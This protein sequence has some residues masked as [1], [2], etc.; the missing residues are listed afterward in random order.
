MPSR[1][2]N[3][4]DINLLHWTGMKEKMSSDKAIDKEAAIAHNAFTQ[5]LVIT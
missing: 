2:S 3:T 1:V 5:M 4:Q